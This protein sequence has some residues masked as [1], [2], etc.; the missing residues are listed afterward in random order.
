MPKNEVGVEVAVGV[1]VLVEECGLVAGEL[2]GH[3][4]IKAA[5]RMNNAVLRS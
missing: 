3:D 2:E 1:A 5:F 4:S